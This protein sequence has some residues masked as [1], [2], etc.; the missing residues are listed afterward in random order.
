[1]KKINVL[2]IG[3][4][5]PPAITGGLAIACEGIARALANRGHKILFM[6]PRLSG[7]ERKVENLELFDVKSKLNELTDEEYELLSLIYTNYSKVPAYSAYASAG[8]V[9]GKS[10]GSSSGA[11]DPAD[12]LG[13]E[14]GYGSH[15][16]DEVNIYARF[17]KIM[18]SRLDFD[19]IHAHDWMTFPAAMAAGAASGKP[20]IC[21][22]HATEFDRSGDNVNPYVYELELRAF[23]AAT[24][25]V[26]VSNYTKQT[27]MNRYGIPSA[28]IETVHNAID[29]EISEEI[30]RRNRPF[31]EKIILFL[32]R[33]TFQ[34]G[35]D[36]FVQAAKKV[37]EKIDNVRFVMVGTGDM[38]YRMIELA[39][40]L[41]I[42]KYFHYTGFLNKDQVRM[43][44][45]MSD[46]YVMPSVS[47]PF[48]L[49][50]LEAMLHGVPVIV[51]KQSGVSEKIQNAVKVDF[52]NVDEIA[53]N[54]LN[55]LLD[56]AGTNRLIES[57]MNEVKGFSWS[58][59]ATQIEKIYYNLIR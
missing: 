49:S 19:V 45:Q 56:H 25:I 30:F 6:I 58:E 23:Q 16:Y 51:S 27:I 13:L 37:I 17:A 20:I 1:M 44:Y 5:F 54:I 41:G 10:R 35:P 9:P 50:P 29:F 46:L 12:L 8:Y 59:S 55:L 2:M 38:Y 31:H 11:D 53:Q 18:S 14:G 15:L 22:V 24:K 43:M 48:G 40:D 7:R 52:W 3:W 21:H 47:E 28:R 36:Y 32:G 39:A 57:A 33:I 26:T 42:G 4:E 34:K